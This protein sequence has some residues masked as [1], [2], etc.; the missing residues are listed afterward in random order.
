[1]PKRD[2]AALEKNIRYTFKNR[3]LLTEALLHASAAKRKS[4]ERL[5]FLGDA[6]LE[7][8]VSEYLYA[9]KKK[10]TEGRLTKTRA[11][12]VTESSLV[13]AA[14]QID[15]NR[16]LILGKSEE[17]SGGREKKSLSAN[18]LEALI[19]AVYLDGGYPAAK[20]LVLRLM[21]T[22]I[23]NVMTGGGFKDYKTRLQEILHKRQ[24]TD[25]AYVTY[26]QKGPPHDRTFY[27]KFLC[28]GKVVSRGFGRSKKSAEQDA[29][30]KALKAL[31]FL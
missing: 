9:L 16:Y 29:A 25:I 14:K 27:V 19:G 6:V 3:E 21:E 4:N 15:L 7:L 2:Y 10:Y 18:A 12:I 28:E 30:K 23:D 26:Q 31:K 17:S 8:I 5:E 20:E 11:A 24:V 1:M 13:S 22:I